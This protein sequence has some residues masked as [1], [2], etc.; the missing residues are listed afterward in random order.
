MGRGMGPRG[1]MGPGGPMGRLPM[2]GRQLGITD[3]QKDQIK[4][5]AASH[6][7][8][9]KALADR[10]RTAHQALQDAVTADTVDEA[11]SG[12]PSGPRDVLNRSNSFHDVFRRDPVSIQQLFR[13]AAPRNLADGEPVHGK[14]GA[15]HGFGHRVADSAAGVMVLDRNQASCGCPARRNQTITIHRRHRIQVDDAN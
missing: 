6:R 14:S 5:I 8:E 15:G 10:A 11:A 7:D 12:R 4:N 1:P 13:L 2:L 3:A 9:G